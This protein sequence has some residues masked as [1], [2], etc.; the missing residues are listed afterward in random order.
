MSIKGKSF[1]VPGT[2]AD[3]TRIGVFPSKTSS[4]LVRTTHS[5][6]FLGVHCFVRKFRNKYDK[7]CVRVVKH[8][9]LGSASSLLPGA[10]SAHG[11]RSSQ[12][13][14]EWLWYLLILLVDFGMDA[15]D[16]VVTLRNL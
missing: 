15:R 6:L 12:W 14:F 1:Q 2:L 4:F 11:N 9:R 7:K 8:K 13:I 16:E 5:I 3:S 10:F